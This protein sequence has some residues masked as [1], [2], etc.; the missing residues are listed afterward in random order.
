MHRRRHLPESRR[1][2]CSQRNFA[3][4]NA[5]KHVAADGRDVA[6]NGVSNIGVVHHGC[7]AVLDQIHVQ[8]R[9][10]VL[11]DIVVFQIKRKRLLLW[12][13]DNGNFRSVLY[14]AVGTVGIDRCI[15]LRNTRNYAVCH[16]ANLCIARRPG[17][18]C[19][20]LAAKLQVSLHSVTFAGKY[21]H[22]SV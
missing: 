16:S 12:G 4:R 17:N 14:S 22:I 10:F 3:R 6:V 21:C 19:H 20:T 11:D 1:G 15:S 9:R 7:F 5:C 18:V 13:N 8:F 2:S